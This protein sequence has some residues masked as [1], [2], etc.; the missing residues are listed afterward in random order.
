MSLTLESS[1]DEAMLAKIMQIPLLMRLGPSER[2]L[3]AMSKPVVEKAKAIAPN[4]KVAKGKEGPTRDKW[5]KNKTEHFDPATWAAVSSGRH[6]KTRYLKNN[7][8]GVLIIGGEHPKANKLNFEAG[9]QRKV[10][11]WGVD[12][13]KV[14]R[15][16]PSERFMQRAYDETKAAQQSAGY[17]QLEKEIKEL[18]LG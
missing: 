3:K 11:Y 18:K 5:G 8:G 1:F 13:G 17:A 4:S 7:R 14:K 9:T 2:V 12:S 10:F 6:I 16:N 15:I